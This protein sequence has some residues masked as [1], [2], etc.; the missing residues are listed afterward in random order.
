MEYI[1]NLSAS[2]F[3]AYAKTH[4]L[5]SYFQNSSWAKTKANW[6]AL[7]VAVKDQQQIVAAAMI[8]LRRLPLGQK[9]AYMPRGPLLDFNDE[10]LL[11]FFFTNL[12]KHLRKQK[13]LLCKIDPNI[14]INKLAFDRNLQ[15]ANEKDDTFVE[16]MR[17]HGLRHLGYSL[18]MHETI[19]PR[20]QLELPTKDYD[21]L[22]PKKTRKK[23][24]NSFNKG[25]IVKNEGNQ[26]DS[27]VKMVNFTESRHGIELR[28]QAYFEHL[29]N[30]FKED[31][32]VLSA[33]LDD[34]LI[35]SGLIVKSKDMAE[36]LY[37]GYDDDFKQYNS[38]YPLR[39]EAIKWAQE[40]GCKYFSFGGVEGSLDDGLTMFKSS[41]GPLVKVFIGEFNLFT[42]PLIS[43]IAALA[44]KTIR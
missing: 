2:E 17:K 11:S 28:N 31:A 40:Q 44:F 18:V 41:F 23:I 3:D 14:V 21:S 4:P 30:A 7:Y 26:V 34:Q 10:N 16:K 12:K 5:N 39:Y 1:S 19:Q 6:Q 38:T 33:Y 35:S 29:L 43:N 37:S 20:I 13:V 32:C 36:I 27:L 24:R 25:V 22:I 8:L 15:L 9:F 42:F